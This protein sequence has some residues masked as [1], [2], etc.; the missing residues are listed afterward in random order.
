MTAGGCLP[1]TGHP[2]DASTLMRR[3]LDLERIYIC[4]GFGNCRDQCVASFVRDG[5]DGG[6][7]VW[8]QGLV[9]RPSAACPFRM[10][11]GP[12]TL[13]QAGNNRIGFPGLLSCSF[14]RPVEA[15]D[16]RNGSRCFDVQ[17]AMLHYSL[18]PATLTGCVIANKGQHTPALYVRYD[19]F[20]CR[21]TEYGSA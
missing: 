21:T 19:R 6:H 9:G 4:A 13:P 3:Q 16:R 7:Q 17:S 1:A 18:P 14:S 20:T 10:R 11:C 5:S 8:R 12:P 2:R 15:M